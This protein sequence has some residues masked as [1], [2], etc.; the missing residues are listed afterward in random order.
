MSTFLKIYQMIL[1]LLE[2]LLIFYMKNAKICLT[3]APMKL[4]YK[5][6]NADRVETQ[7]AYFGHTSEF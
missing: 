5:K 1:D 3:H 6:K 7:S 2:K 4:T